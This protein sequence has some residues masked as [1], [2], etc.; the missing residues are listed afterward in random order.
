MN[1]HDEEL[2]RSLR[3]L[4]VAEPDAVRLERLRARCH[5]SLLARRHQADLQRSRRAFAARVLEPVFVGGLSVSYL[6]A[7]LFVLL[8]MHGII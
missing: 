4:H 8:R 3:D 2:L 6:L 1:M 5:A 7:I